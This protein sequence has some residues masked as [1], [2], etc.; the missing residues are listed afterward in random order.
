VQQSVF[1][2]RGELAAVRAPHR[3]V[4][5]DDLALGASERQ[6]VARSVD[7][8]ELAAMPGFGAELFAA[9]RVEIVSQPAQIALEMCDRRGRRPLR[10]QAISSGGGRGDRG[11]V[12]LGTARDRGDV[13][14][15]RLGITHG[16]CEIPP[17]D[18]LIA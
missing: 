16:A 14:G 17:P 5:F 13:V 9:S 10:E 7:R 2:A 11:S 8:R 15:E 12:S 18:A 6:A 1:A 3:K 4:A